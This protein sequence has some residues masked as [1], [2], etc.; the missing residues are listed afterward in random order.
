MAIMLDDCDWRRLY[1]ESALHGAAKFRL[2]KTAPR[3][4]AGLGETSDR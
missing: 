4:A 1:G 2:S 3:E